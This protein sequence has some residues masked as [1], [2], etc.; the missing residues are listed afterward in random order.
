MSDPTPAGQIPAGWYVDSVDQRLVRYW[1]GV[2][3]TEHVEVRQAPPPVMTQESGPLSPELGWS[4]GDRV[5]QGAAEIDPSQLEAQ[6]PDVAARLSPRL[7]IV[8]AIGA[9]LML[10]GLGSV[11][12][13]RGGST[14]NPRGDQA[15]AKVGE[16]LKCID[17]YDGYDYGAGDNS[18]AQV[19]E[20]VRIDVPSS[21]YTDD[22]GVAFSSRFSGAVAIL[23]T[24]QP[25]GT[26]HARIAITLMPWSASYRPEIIEWANELP[27]LVAPPMVR[28]TPATVASVCI[29]GMTGPDLSQLASEL[30][31]QGQFV[32]HF[33][34][35]I[36]DET[37]VGRLL[38]FNEKDEPGDAII[39]EATVVADRVGG[40]VHAFTSWPEVKGSA[41]TASPNSTPKKSKARKGKPA[42]CAPV[43]AIDSSGDGS[44]DGIGHDL[45]ITFGTAAEHDAAIFNLF[46][47]PW[48]DALLT[49]GS[50]EVG[51]ELLVHPGE[52]EVAETLSTWAKSQPGFVGITEP[53]GPP[54]IA[55]GV[56]IAL[57]Q[58]DS[59]ILAN[60]LGTLAS[61]AAAERGVRYVYSMSLSE[62]RTKSWYE[63]LILRTEGAAHDYEAIA[64]QLA[65]ETEATWWVS[66]D[67]WG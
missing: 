36:D 13:N 49:V 25:E 51:R 7:L 41:A 62:D 65:A 33:W 67:T 60:R 63:V 46:D 27:N 40:S 20:D 9:V 28:T 31:N 34:Y 66:P 21:E 53:A 6:R 23:S 10:I 32:S 57:E 38:F 5:E 44:T 30:R 42:K 43:G 19:I 54:V 50:S 59:D 47:Q 61:A 17:K 16:E 37:S 11:V 1:D 22:L 48:R 52:S 56:C 12:L 64:Q 3:W 8:A 45:S 2:R 24:G 26:D 35:R 14:A 58:D 29:P 39:A 55:A 18:T 4:D 15:A